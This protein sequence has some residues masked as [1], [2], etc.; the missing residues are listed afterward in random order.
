MLTGTLHLPTDPHSEEPGDQRKEGNATHIF[1][2]T[3]TQVR[4]EFQDS[5]HIFTYS[6]GKDLAECFYFSGARVYYIVFL[7]PLNH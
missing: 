3:F 5:P 2:S 1:G 7:P 6:Y 4:S